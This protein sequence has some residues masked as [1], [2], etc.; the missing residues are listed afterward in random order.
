MTALTVRAI[1]VKVIIASESGM[2][3]R[4]GTREQ[5]GSNRICPF[6]RE[7]GEYR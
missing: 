7:K 3:G 4:F 5:V 2:I 1:R 6:C